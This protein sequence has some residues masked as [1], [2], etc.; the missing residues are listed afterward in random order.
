MYIYSPSRYW[1]RPYR[2]LKVDCIVFVCTLV[3]K[4]T[5]RL[6]FQIHFLYQYSL[7]FFLDIF[8]AVLRRNKR[9]SGVKEY[10]ARLSIITADLFQVRRLHFYSTPH[11]NTDFTQFWFLPKKSK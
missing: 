4:C 5:R 1:T 8:S 3:H 2:A 11:F 9:L 10:A 7:Q 6:Y